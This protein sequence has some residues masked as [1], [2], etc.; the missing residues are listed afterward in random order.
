MLTAQNISNLKNEKIPFFRFKKF[1]N[2]K[3]IITND[4]WKF[5]FLNNADFFLYV[6]WEVDHLNQYEELVQNWFIK[7]DSYIDKMT[8]SFALRNS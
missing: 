3:Y 4:A 2:T 8:W 5:I 7:D 6:S 1:D